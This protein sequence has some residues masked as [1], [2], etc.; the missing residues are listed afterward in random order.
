MN[1]L[2]R[3]SFLASTAAVCLRAAA[4]SERLGIACHLSTDETASRNVLRV[5]REAGYTIAQLQFP[6]SKVGDEYLRALPR[7][8]KDEGIVGDVVGAYVNCVSPSNV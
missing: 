5:A 2:T 6:W 4:P 1:T 7:W 3:R 8:L